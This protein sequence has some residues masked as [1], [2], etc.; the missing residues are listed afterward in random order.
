M[1][2]RGI[3]TPDMDVAWV[4]SLSWYFLNLF[5]LRAVFEWILGQDQSADG[6]Q[7]MQQM[8][9][10]QQAPAGM[11]PSAAE[12]IKQAWQSE[13]ESLDLIAHQW[14]LDLIEKRLLQRWALSSDTPAAAESKKIQ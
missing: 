1:L 8:A 2:Q 9:G 5:G 10:Q 6:L 13:K 4:S 12:R 7:D 3:E 14:D 11:G